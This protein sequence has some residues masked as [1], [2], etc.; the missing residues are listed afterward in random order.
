M[1]I[2][3]NILVATDF[4][5]SATNAL[6]YAINLAQQINAKLYV[7]HVKDI[8]DTES[9]LS[10]IKIEE[11]FA[12]IRHD[13]LFLRNIETKFI[14]EEGP[15]AEV[16]IKEAKSNH[17]DLAVIGVKGA[18][19]IREGSFGSI[20]AKVIDHMP[21][22][23]ICVPANCR[24][25][26]FEKVLIAVDFNHPLNLP[27]LYVISFIAEA[28]STQIKILNVQYNNDTDDEQT[29]KEML[30]LKD[31]FKYSML[32]FHSFSAEADKIVK[33]ISNYALE[34]TIDLITVFHLINNRGQPFKRSK[35]KQLALTSQ[36]PLLIIPMESN[37]FKY[38]V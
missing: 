34:N 25:L 28:F 5:K 2:L 35:S 21:C 29:T 17:I 12:A 26:S 16:I 6:V 36:L 1:Q 9:R 24:V 8:K 7:L 30:K 31:L 10:D 20:T 27:A 4:S 37:L 15:I 32:D 38:H 19:G 23:V 11:K 33:G 22:A 18:S 3:K 13:F 14:T